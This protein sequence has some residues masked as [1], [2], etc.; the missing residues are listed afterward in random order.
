M[1]EVLAKLAEYHAWGV[2]HVWLIDPDKRRFQVFDGV[3]LNSSPA[4]SLAEHGVC[5][6]ATELFDASDRLAPKR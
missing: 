2:K 4:L 5:I 1:P 6:L 3:G